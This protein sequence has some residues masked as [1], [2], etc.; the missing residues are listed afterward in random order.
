MIILSRDMR[1]RPTNRG[2]NPLNP[3][4]IIHDNISSQVVD[5]RR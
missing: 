1:E 5:K 4:S 2:S 3:N